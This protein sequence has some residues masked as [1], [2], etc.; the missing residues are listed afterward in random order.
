MPSDGKDLFRECLWNIVRPRGGDRSE[1]P[2]PHRMLPQVFAAEL[3][4]EWFPKAGRATYFLFKKNLRVTN[5]QFAELMALIRAE[6]RTEAARPAPEIQFVSPDEFTRAISRIVE[7]LGSDVSASLPNQ[8]TELYW[9]IIERIVVIR[10]F[11]SAALVFVPPHLALDIAAVCGY[12]GYVHSCGPR[13]YAR[14][15]DKATPGEFEAALHDYLDTRLRLPPN[16]RL[17]LAPYSHEDYTDYDRDFADELRSGL[18]DVKLHVEKFFI[19]NQRL[20]SFINY[21]RM[22]EPRILVPPPGPFT[23]TLPPLR[24]LPGTRL[25]RLAWLI[26]D[27]NTSDELRHP[28]PHKYFICYDQEFKNENPYHVYDETKPAWTAP[29]TIPHT[30]AGAMINIARPDIDTTP[31]ATTLCDPFVGSGTIWMEALKYP[32]FNASCSDLSEISPRLC[33]DNLRF[34]HIGT[35]ELRALE[36]RLR[37]VISYVEGGEGTTKTQERVQRAQQRFLLLTNLADMV[38]MHD[39]TFTKDFVNDLPRSRFERLLF[40]LVVRTTVRNLAAFIRRQADAREPFDDE[41]RHAYVSEA[42]KFLRQT[43]QL[44]LLRERIE[45]FG[46]VAGR[47]HLLIADGEYSRACSVASPDGDWH[48]YQTEVWDACDLEQR[49]RPDVIVT[50]PPYGFNTEED[51]VEFARFYAKMIPSLIR[52]LRPGG[53]LVLCLPD[54]SFNGRRMFFFANKDLVV[55]QVL[56]AAEDLGLHV[57]VPGFS[58]PEPVRLFRPPYYW[59]S[60]R[61]LRRAILHFRFESM[62]NQSSTTAQGDDLTSSNRALS[63]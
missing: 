47:P 37:E 17:I 30:L 52:A 45:S 49:F 28:G 27:H 6:L 54:L 59:E 18:D 53:Q 20:V 25:D 56:R 57:S 61:A 51:P 5:I 38:N 31:G 50:D 24:G 10:P 9:P 32:E 34:I 36:P 8:I 39:A 1:G 16:E 55:Q 33:V 62:A 42:N 40:Y 41:W 19:G 13:I 3:F 43:R 2:A 23:S 26:L 63:G 7:G 44:L 14:R 12:S 29:N 22:A 15:I 46:V 4:N 48:T 58:V 11:F 21:L 60:E 35:H